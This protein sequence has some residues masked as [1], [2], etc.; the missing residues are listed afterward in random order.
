MK[1]NK[2]KVQKKLAK[3]AVKKE[4]EKT[5]TEKFLEVINQLGHEAENLG[6]D[7]GK[8]GKKVV[9]NISNKFSEVKEV[10]INNNIEKSP[11]K[12]H[13]LKKQIVK[14]TPHKKAALSIGIKEAE[15]TVKKA[16]A[17]VK[18]VV[19]SVKVAPIVT[20]EKVASAI[21][22]PPVANRAPS[23][24]NKAKVMPKVVTPK[25]DDTIVK[26]K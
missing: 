12:E 19:Q 2:P 15:K 11:A 16:V 6:I 23:G 18:P 21:V 7:I 14:K 1:T 25:K 9:K 17:Q 20:E 22:K 10:V 8:I 24:A 5:L 26:I 4:L 13:T 3:K